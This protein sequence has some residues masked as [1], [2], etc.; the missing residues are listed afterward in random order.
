MRTIFT[1]IT[2]VTFNGEKSSLISP[3]FEIL[4]DGL[5]IDS[6]ENVFVN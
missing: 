3:K 4:N 1:G 2:I 6:I 5:H